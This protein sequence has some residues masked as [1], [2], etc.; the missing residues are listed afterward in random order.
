M[1]WTLDLMSLVISFLNMVFNVE[2]ICTSCF[3]CID[4]YAYCD[5]NLLDD[6]IVFSLTP[7]ILKHGV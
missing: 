7:L 5:A 1:S 3:N 2:M 4:I 6:N